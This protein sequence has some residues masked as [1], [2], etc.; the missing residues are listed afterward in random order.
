MNCIIPVKLKGCV[1]TYGEGFDNTWL[2]GSQ[3]PLFLLSFSVR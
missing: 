3:I 1:Y 2:Y